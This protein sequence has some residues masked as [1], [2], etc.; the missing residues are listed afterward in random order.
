MFVSDSVTIRQFFPDI[1]LIKY[2]TFKIQLLGHSQGQN[3]WPYLKPILQYVCFLFCGNWTIF[4]WDST[5]SIFDLMIGNLLAKAINC[6]KK[7]MKS[8]HGSVQKTHFKICWLFPDFSPNYFKTHWQSIIPQISA[9][10]VSI[11]YNVPLKLFRRNSVVFNS[12]KTM[13]MCIGSNSDPPARVVSL[14]GSP[15]TWTWRIKHL[16]NILT[17]DLKVSEDITL[18]KV[19]LYHRSTGLTTKCL[20]YLAMLRASCCKHIAVRGMDVKHGTSPASLHARWT[21]NGIKL[22]AVHC[23]FLTRCI[24]IFCL[25]WSKE[26]PL[27]L[28]ISPACQNLYNLLLVQIIPLSFL[29]EHWHVTFPLVLLVGTTQGAKIQP[30]L[31]SPTQTLL[32]RS[33]CI[34]GFYRM[35]AMGS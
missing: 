2:L 12:K 23:I 35:C 27:W 32:A 3:G 30:V 4:P 31:K 28:N 25:C 17:C 11:F 24:Q 21:L 10:F 6:A 5:N 14:N 13:C 8:Q 15:L 1:W 16:G 20:K 29:L 22:F 33:D 18:K 26:N 7:W 9:I 19:P 34:R